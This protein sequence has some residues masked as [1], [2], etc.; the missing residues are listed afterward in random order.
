M[1][2]SVARSRQYHFAAERRRTCPTDAFWLWVMRSPHQQRM[3]LVDRAFT[4][5]L[6]Q[7]PGDGVSSFLRHYACCDA[8]AHIAWA[9]IEGRTPQEGLDWDFDSKLRG[10]KHPLTLADMKNVLRK[11]DPGLGDDVIERVFKGDKHSPF[12]SGSA[13]F[14]RSKIMHEL[15]Q[16]AVEQVQARGAQL[17]ADMQAVIAAL[18]I[19]AAD[20]AGI[21][22]VD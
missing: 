9:A 2:R 18:K 1:M 14:L 8:L 4:N 6:S 15:R 16:E 12:A 5:E 17:L 19:K 10:D 20:P 7:V 22:T 11:V 13:K 21:R 3:M